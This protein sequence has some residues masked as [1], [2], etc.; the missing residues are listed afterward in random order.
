MDNQTDK[1][2]QSPL[3]SVVVLH[4]NQ[5][6][7]WREAVLSVLRQDYPA[8]ELVFQDDASATFVQKD[9]EA[10]I[11]EHKQ[12]NL[13][14]YVVQSNPRN[15][16]T[17]ENC[18]N[19]AAACTGEY[20]LFLDGDDALAEDD[21]VSKFV[22]SFAALPDSENIVTANCQI[23]D[24]KLVGD[25]ILRTKEDCEK[26]D[27]LTARQQYEMLYTNFFPVPSCTAFRR[28]IFT[29]CGGFKVP[30]IVY[31]QDGYYYCHVARLGNK[32][33][34]VEFVASK[35]RAGGIAANKTHALSANQIALVVEFMHVGEQE[36]FPYLDTFSEENRDAIIARYY[37]NLSS[38]R[39]ATDG[40][41]DYGIPE[42]GYALLCR[43]S[44]KVGVASDFQKRTFKYCLST[45]LKKSKIQIANV[46]KR[47]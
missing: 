40:G 47:T 33:H 30:H 27:A 25:R 36:Y 29:Q 41:I 24:E 21:V 37:E 9:V 2:L 10:F 42:P 31:S 3:F 44:K 19:G 45:V 5:P 28:R 17:A 18:D 38:Y 23:C 32:F 4:Y 22:A 7:Y 26:L 1:V 12:E 8:L 34:A 39:M 11:E 14:R 13:Q 46:L 15:A 20:V 43:W 16:G 35:H 6:D